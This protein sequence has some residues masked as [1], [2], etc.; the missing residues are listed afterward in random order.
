MDTQPSLEVRVESLEASL[1][2]TRRFALF[3]AVLLVLFVSAAFGG[4][5][6]EIRTSK[7]I[8][9]KA[10]SSGGV[11]LVAGEDSSLIIQAPDGSEVLRLG[12]SPLRRVGEE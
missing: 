8:L 10:E 11:S 2:R 7:L 12:G 6:D 3:L 9:M 4:E 1:N 5:K